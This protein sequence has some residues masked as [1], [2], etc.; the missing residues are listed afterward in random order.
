M[1]RLYLPAVIQCAAEC[2][3][4]FSAVLA[5]V[6]VSELQVMRIAQ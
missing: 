6:E 2:S 5:A 4:E 1:I 3:L